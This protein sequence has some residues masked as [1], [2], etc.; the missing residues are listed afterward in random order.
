MTSEQITSIKAVR[1]ARCRRAIARTGGKPWTVWLIAS[2]RPVDAGTV[3]C[4]C[5]D[6]SGPVAFAKFGEADAWCEWIKGQFLREC[7][8]EVRRV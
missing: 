2:N 3:P 8:Y 4:R 7:S 1:A 5:E 6:S